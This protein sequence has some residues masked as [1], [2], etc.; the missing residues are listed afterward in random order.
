[1]EHCWTPPPIVDPLI[2]SSFQSDN[3]VVLRS[4][5]AVLIA[6][7]TVREPDVRPV[8]DRPKRKEKICNENDLSRRGAKG[9]RLLGNFPKNPS[10][11]D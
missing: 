1:M 6:I 9:N 3:P 7:A 11:T 5:S 10:G 2:H 8:E 4:L